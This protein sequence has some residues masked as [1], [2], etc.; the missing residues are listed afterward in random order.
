MIPTFTFTTREQYLE[1][2]AQWKERYFGTI[3][4]I[5]EA[6][7][8]KRDAFRLVSKEEPYSN[9][10]YAAL[11][12]AHEAFYAHNRL[13]NDAYNLLQERGYSKI[14]AGKQREK[15]LVAA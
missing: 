7:I 5:R 4:K 6:A 8:A 3:K 2:K 12:P 10:W 11:K 9:A 1:Y 14:E 13:K 15:R